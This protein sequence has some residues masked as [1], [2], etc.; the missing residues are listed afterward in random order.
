MGNRDRD[1]G[2]LIINLLLGDII[3]CIGLLLLLL[4]MV[5]EIF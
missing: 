2:I 5:K 4:I 3:Y 1:P